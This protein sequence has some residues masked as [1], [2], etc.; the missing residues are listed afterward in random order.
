[1]VYTGQDV[2]RM[3]LKAQARG[4]RV[5]SCLVQEMTSQAAQGNAK[6]T[7]RKKTP[8]GTAQA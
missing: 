6:Q 8:K 5:L 4:F 3:S 7:L 2:Q 1:M